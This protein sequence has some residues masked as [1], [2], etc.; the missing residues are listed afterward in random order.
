MGVPEVSIDQSQEQENQ[1]RQPIGIGKELAEMAQQQDQMIQEMQES[2]DNLIKTQIFT[3]KKIDEVVELRKKL[4]C[5][6]KLLLDWEA[7]LLERHLE[8]VQTDINQRADFAR[9]QESL[10][11]Q[12]ISPTVDRALSQ[13]L[14]SGSMLRL[15]VVALVIVIIILMKLSN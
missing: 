12:S 1:V 11:K 9:M 4:K 3:I 14:V 15:I 7:R 8:I 5:K 2:M 6:E 13:T 10:R